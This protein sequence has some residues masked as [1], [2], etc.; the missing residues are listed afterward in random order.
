MCKPTHNLID[1]PDGITLCEFLPTFA[2][3]KHEVLIGEPN[4]ECASYGKRLSEVRKRRGRIRLFPANS[5]VPIIHQF[6]VCGR[7]AYLYQRGGEAHF[8]DEVM[9]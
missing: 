5:P 2:D 9:Q 6:Y 7:C 8:E 4:S 1:I 3:F